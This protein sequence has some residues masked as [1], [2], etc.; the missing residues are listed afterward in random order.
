IDV[1]AR[2]DIYEALLEMKEK[3]IAIILVSDDPKEY[4]MLCDKIIFLKGGR[5]QKVLS[6]QEFKEVIAT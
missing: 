6:S 3:K 5:V 2:R 1:G 4:S